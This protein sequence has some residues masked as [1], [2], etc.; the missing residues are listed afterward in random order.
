MMASSSFPH[1]SIVPT[2]DANER[3]RDMT[4]D[5]MNVESDVLCLK[6]CLW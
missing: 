2:R 4:R 5:R 6:K 3:T 1:Q